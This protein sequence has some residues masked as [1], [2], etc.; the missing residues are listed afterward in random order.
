VHGLWRLCACRE[1]MRLTI[2][3][4]KDLEIAYIGGEGTTRDTKSA[5]EAMNVL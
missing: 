1:A 5:V 2:V 3:Y 4:R